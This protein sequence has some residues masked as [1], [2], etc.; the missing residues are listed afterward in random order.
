MNI[1]KVLTLLVLPLTLALSSCNNDTPKY[2][3]PELAVTDAEGGELTTV[4]LPKEGGSVTFKVTANR[5]WS[6]TG[7]PEWFGVAPSS[8]NIK[9]QQ[10]KTTEVTVTAA[11]NTADVRT[12]TIKVSMDKMSVDI[13]VTQE[14]GI[15]REYKTI[16][17]IRALYT[18]SNVTITPAEGQTA[19]WVKGTVVSNARKATANGLNNFGSDKI[20]VIQDE[21]AGIELFCS[22][23]PDFAPGDIV[24]ANI[25]NSTLSTYAEALQLSNVVVANISKI[26]AETLTAKEITAAELLTGNYEW[27]YVAV[28]DVQVVSA[29]LSKKIAEGAA[30]ST[31][32]TTSINLESKDG[33][34]LVLFSGKYATPLSTIAVPQGSGTLKGI[35]GRYN[36]TFQIYL[37]YVTDIDGMTA[38]RFTPTITKTTISGITKEGNYEVAG[39]TVLATYARGFLAGDSTGKILVY[40]EAVPTVGAGDVVTINGTVSTYAGMFQ[41]GTNTTVTKTGTTTV[42]HG[43]ATSMDGAAMDAYLAAPT[44]KY[45]EYKG[46]LTISG[47]HYNV[48]VSGASTAIGSISYPATGLVDASLNGKDI[49]VTGYTIGVNSSKYVNTMALSV[50]ADANATSL[51]VSP[52]SLSWAAAET[53]AK[54]VTVT[55]NADSWSMDASSIESWATVTKEGNVITVTPK[56]ANT[57]TSADNSGIIKITAGDKSVDVKATQSKVVSGNQIV[58]TYDSAVAGK[59]GTVALTQ[60]SYGSQAVAD[61]NT[62]YNWTNNGFE[63]TGVKICQGKGNGDAYVECLQQ[64]GHA[65]DAPKQGMLGN[66]TAIGTKITSITIVAL[67]TNSSYAPSANLYVGSSAMPKGGTAVQASTKESATSGSV[68]T[69]TWTYDLSSLNVQYFNFYN[70]TTGANYY[71]SITIE[72]E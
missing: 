60:N 28:K 13:N 64:Q 49:I 54:T 15:V 71:K 20:L 23:A 33:E 19:V 39:A 8:V 22:A 61:T 47:N 34:T 58:I 51:S 67:N 4:T 62:W 45:V 52:T 14:S 21:T 46:K 10:S 40:L 29:D 65:S 1:R 2:V 59:T 16:A 43:T 9:N 31:A 11:A 41:F 30:A 57:S 37:T 69:F 68:T 66:K 32:T 6:I 12:K 48:A 17:S 36:N 42:D 53:T 55:T 3:L 24:E 72:Y 7:T 25:A 35:A 50:V 56:A 26:S 63:F 18:G 27:Q 38:E 70:N 5:S 44:I